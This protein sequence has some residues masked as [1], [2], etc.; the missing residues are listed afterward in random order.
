MK[1]ILFLADSASLQSVSFHVK[2]VNLEPF[3]T[4]ADNLS[5]IHLGERPAAAND[6]ILSHSHHCFP[7]TPLV[8]R[9]YR[10][11]HAVCMC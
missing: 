1:D 10:N 3:G 11:R 7:H 8:S 9:S 2:R 4:Q 5:L 6:F